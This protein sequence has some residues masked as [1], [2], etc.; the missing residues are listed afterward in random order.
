MQEGDY[1]KG[2]RRKLRGELKF[3][4]AENPTESASLSI[5]WIAMII[6]VL[7]NSF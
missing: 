6:T 7:P 2:S 5:F 4:M 3:R 1:R